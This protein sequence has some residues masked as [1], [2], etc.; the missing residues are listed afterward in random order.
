MII[1]CKFVFFFAKFV[2]RAHAWVTSMEFVLIS[3]TCLAPKLTTKM[4]LICY[5]LFVELVSG[6]SSVKPTRINKG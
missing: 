6:S 4:L 2:N 3:E 1:A 5:V